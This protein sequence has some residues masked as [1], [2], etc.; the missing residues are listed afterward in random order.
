MTPSAGQRVLHLVEPWAGPPTG[1]SHRGAGQDALT[2][3]CS[4]CAGPEDTTLVIG[5]ARALRRAAAAGLRPQAA[6]CPPLARVEFAARAVRRYIRAAGPFDAA[7]CW[8]GRVGR[9][10]PAVARLLPSV[11]VASFEDASSAASIMPPDSSRTE[12]A[13]RRWRE[14]RGL[15][16]DDVLIALLDDP[17]SFPSAR[18][19]A[20]ILGA[21]EVSGMR[22]VGLVPSGTSELARARRFRRSVG[23][24]NRLLIADR[25]LTSILA[26]CDLGLLLGPVAAPGPARFL[27][28][29]AGAAGVPVITA[30]DD[31]L[32]RDLP[33]VVRARC[34][35]SSD[36]TTDLGRLLLELT[37]DRPG[38]EQLSAELREHWRAGAGIQAP[39]FSPVPARRPA[40]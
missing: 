37:E 23:L 6:I 8:G 34:L 20:F 31:R 33:G 21:L 10:A 2:A 26:A 16:P 5:P 32:T 38:R 35:A 36:H 3:A 29:L 13:A 25:P 22:P 30:T 7:V 15:S 28:H 24:R 17:A 27:L 39:A 14:A 9:L 19:F 18:K 4:L 12:V 11:R 40:R 1:R